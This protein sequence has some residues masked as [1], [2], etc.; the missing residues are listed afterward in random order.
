MNA[1]AIGRLTARHSGSL[2]TTQ[3]KA[4]AA[5]EIGALTSTEL[6]GWN[7][8]Q[9]GEIGRAS[10]REIAKISVVAVSIKKKGALRTTQVR[11]LTPAQPNG[12]AGSRLQAL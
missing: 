2:T 9:V 7:A 10:C 12:I 8:G 6:Q 5:A 3:I 1:A 11:G 4:L